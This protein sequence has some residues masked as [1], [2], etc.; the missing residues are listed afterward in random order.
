MA[1]LGS[2]FPFLRERKR[3]KRARAKLRRVVVQGHT[4]Y[5]KPAAHNRHTC[6]ECRRRRG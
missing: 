1:V 6:A 4:Y 2:L 3:R 5:V